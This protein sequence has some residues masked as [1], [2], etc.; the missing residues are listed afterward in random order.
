[1]GSKKKIGGAELEKE[2]EFLKSKM[3]EHFRFF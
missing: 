3:K 2:L 1:V